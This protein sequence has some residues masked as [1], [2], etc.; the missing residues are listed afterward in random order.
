[1]WPIGLL[2]Y[3]VVKIDVRNWSVKSYGGK[4]NGG[5]STNLSY[6]LYEIEVKTQPFKMKASVANFTYT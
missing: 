5:R 2:F 3:F 1:M 4:G 6:L